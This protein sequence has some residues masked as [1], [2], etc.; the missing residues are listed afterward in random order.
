MSQFLAMDKLPSWVPIH[1]FNEPVYNYK[2]GPEVV[3]FSKK[4][5]WAF[6]GM[7]AFNPI[8][9]NI[10]ARNGAFVF[11]LSPAALWR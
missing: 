8:F 10:V 7:V 5:L 4:S 9:W 1:H 11:H 3:D 2:T 6:V